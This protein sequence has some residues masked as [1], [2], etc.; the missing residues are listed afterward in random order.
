MILL[1]SLAWL[2]QLCL[3]LAHAAQMSRDGGGV[4]AWCGDGDG[5]APAL[6]ARIAAF[7]PELRRILMPVAGNT[8]T[9]NDH[10][11]EHCS[12][13]GGGAQLPAPAPTA[14]LRQAGLEPAVA[15]ATPSPR[16]PCASPLPARGPPNRS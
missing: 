16:A 1:A 2:A 13:G 15:A 11:A 12:P 7:P 4:V 9:P 10:C 8:S 14:A 3:P 6:R 5:L